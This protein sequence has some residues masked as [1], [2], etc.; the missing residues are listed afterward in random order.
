M[1]ASEVL[2]ERGLAAERFRARSDGADV[3]PFACVDA[4][5]SCETR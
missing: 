3:R 2:S 5:M 1:C 4:S